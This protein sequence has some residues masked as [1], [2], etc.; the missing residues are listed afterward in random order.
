MGRFNAAPMS[1]S[2]WNVDWESST[3][4]V[5][6]RVKDEAARLG[7]DYLGTRHLLL[8]LV[9]SAP[10]VGVP[11]LSVEAAR[12]AVA[13][14]KEPRQPGM[15]LLTP[16]CQTPGLKVVVESA[17]QRAWAESRSVTCSDLWDGLLDDPESECWPV[18]HRF[19]VDA[20]LLR[21]RPRT[22]RCT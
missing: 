2:F 12:E 6:A 3:R 5:F 8:A 16:W 19:G 20:Q 9:A 1:D 7:D 15:M 10:I 22:S 21:D 18:L 4:D 13:A 11:G 17:M 14:L